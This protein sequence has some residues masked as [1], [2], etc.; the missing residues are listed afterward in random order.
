M[1]PRLS[2]F[3][4]V[5]HIYENAPYQ[6][7]TEEE[8]EEAIKTFPKLDW[9]KLQEYETMDATT[10]SQEFACSGDKGCEL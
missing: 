10:G 4:K 1:P 2:F 3:P 6:A 9:D 5:D 7:I 8:Y